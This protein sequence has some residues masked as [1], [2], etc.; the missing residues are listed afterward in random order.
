[1]TRAQRATKGHEPMRIA[2]VYDAVYPWKTGGV[3]KRVWEVARRLAERHDVHWYGLHYWDGP[4]VIERDGVTLHGVG[5]PRPLYVDGRRSIR[6]AL[7][8][9]GRL[10]SSLL[11]EEFDI[12]DCQEFPYFPCFS[13]KLHSVVRD[14]S[15]VLTWHEVW[16]DYWYGYLDWKGVF[17][18]MVERAVAKLPDCHVAVSQRTADDLRAFGVSDTRVVPNGVDFEMI[19]SVDDSGSP[20][21]TPST[22]DLG[23]LFVGR[24]TKGKNAN[25][26]LMAVSELLNR[27]SDI[28]CT[29]VGEGPER[30]NIEQT[31]ASL[32]L[33]DRVSVLEPRQEHEDIIKFM[34]SADVFVLPSQREGFGIT[35]LEALAS[36]TPVVTVRH[37][38]NAASELVT[39]KETGSVTDPTPS[40]VA[41]GVE[42]A[43]EHVSS[44]DCV[45]AAK[46]YQWGEVADAMELVY[47]DHLA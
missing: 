27:R 3:Q 26:L 10:L 8:F 41:D 11:D 39:K 30:E 32:S 7:S 33:E 22:D 47:Q 45:S 28:H 6:Q 15:M 5:K 25:L 18:K 14:T 24:F 4:S 35:V 43:V 13:S 29:L 40:S 23:L 46:Q 19:Q 37:P 38:Q 34:K 20:D 16:G 42:S 31:V 21:L 36:G 1:M 17:G 9:S 44:A 2:Y 12:I